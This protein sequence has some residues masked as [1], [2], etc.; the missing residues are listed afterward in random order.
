[1]K[2]TISRKSTADTYVQLCSVCFCESMND[3]K[4]TAIQNCFNT[5]MNEFNIDISII[6][7]NWLYNIGIISTRHRT[8]FKQS[9][10]ARLK[11]NATTNT[12][13]T[14]QWKGSTVSM[15]VMLL[16]QAWSYSKSTLSHRLIERVVRTCQKPAAL[17]TTKKNRRKC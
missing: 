17:I 14:P 13:V 10:W 16:Y 4:L 9:L 15:Y 2:S 12:N 3:T 8:S 7:T 1:M 6:V 11:G 5:S